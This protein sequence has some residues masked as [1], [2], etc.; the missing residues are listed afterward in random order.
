MAWLPAK[1]HVLWPK[2]YLKI[3]FLPHSKCSLSSLQR[4]ISSWCWGN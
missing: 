4:L 1:L 2:S 3:Q